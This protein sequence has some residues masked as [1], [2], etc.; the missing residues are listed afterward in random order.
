MKT[1]FLQGYAWKHLYKSYYYHG[2]LMH[3]LTPPDPK[4][5][6]Y[7][8]ITPPPPPTLFNYTCDVLP[9]NFIPP[10]VIQTGSYGYTLSVSGGFLYI[11]ATI[12]HTDFSYS[13]AVISQ[14]YFTNHM[15][16]ILG[17]PA[18]TPPSGPGHDWDAAKGVIML[19][20]YYEGWGLIEYFDTWYYLNGHWI[21][22]NQGYHIYTAVTHLDKVYHI[23]YFGFY[24][25]FNYNP[26]TNITTANYCGL[27]TDT[28]AGKIRIKPAFM[29]A[30]QPYHPTILIDYENIVIE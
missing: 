5:F 29:G 28:F 1:A 17:A 9:Q 27:F 6:I 10:Y 16:F 21:N 14:D 19:Y 18:M 7:Y 12:P 20:N 4:P 13:G 23:P 25:D 11:A 8:P 2:I 3:C 22:Y 30:G 26:I 15:R 24:M